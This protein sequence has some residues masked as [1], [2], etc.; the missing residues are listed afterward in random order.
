MTSAMGIS[1]LFCGCCEFIFDHLRRR[2]YLVLRTRPHLH[3]PVGLAFF[4]ARIFGLIDFNRSRGMIAL[5]ELTGRCR[6]RLL[7]ASNGGE[8]SN[9]KFQRGDKTGL[10]ANIDSSLGDGSE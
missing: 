2:L 4:N 8:I 5:R 9:L 3:T 10:S 7:P 1:R 6:C